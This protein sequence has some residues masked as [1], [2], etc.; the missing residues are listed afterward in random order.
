M[1][2]EDGSNGRRE[3]ERKEME[4]GWWAW[5]DERVLEKEGEKGWVGG[6]NKLKLISLNAGL[7][8]R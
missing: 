7:L 3:W 8:V 6:R 5:K 2:D 1:K 4:G